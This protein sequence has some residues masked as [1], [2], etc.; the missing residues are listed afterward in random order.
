MAGSGTTL[1]GAQ[2]PLPA[3]EALAAQRAAGRI[4][5]PGAGRVEQQQVGR[6]DAAAVIAGSRAGM[7]PLLSLRARPAIH[8]NDP[9]FSPVFTRRLSRRLPDGCRLEGRHDDAAVNAG[10]RIGM[11]KRGRRSGVIAGSTRN[12][13]Q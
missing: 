12:P 13:F 11:T 2:A 10:S 4:V 9:Q 8:F 7:T 6:H 1:P 3:R 5:E